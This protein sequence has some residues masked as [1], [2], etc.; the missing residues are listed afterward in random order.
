ML[1]RKGNRL[2]KVG[3]DAGIRLEVA[4]DHLLCLGARN[5]ERGGKAVRLLPVDNAK[6]NGLG[7]AAQLRRDLFDGNA[8]DARGG[9]GVEVRTLVER[10]NQMLVTGEVRKQPQLD[11]RVVAGEKHGALGHREGS[12]H[13]MP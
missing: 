7:T 13:A 2:V 3:A 9:C 6:V 1:V 12:A 8:K 5:L 4:V 10:R 11:L